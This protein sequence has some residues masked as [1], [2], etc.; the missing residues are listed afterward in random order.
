MENHQ[1]LVIGEKYE[2]V[3]V[4]KRGEETREI[5]AY[6]R[7]LGEHGWFKD[8]T[9]YESENF[10]AHK[11]ALQGIGFTISEWQKIPA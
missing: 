4:F 9:C 7:V 2:W 10:E 8:H 6:E 5:F 11:S 1:E 3:A